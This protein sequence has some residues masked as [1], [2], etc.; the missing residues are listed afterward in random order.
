MNKRQGL[1]DRFPRALHDLLVGVITAVCVLMLAQIVAM[2]G[3]TGLL[4]L[5]LGIIAAWLLG[6]VVSKLLGLEL[7]QP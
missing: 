2:A 1:H 7:W 4:L 3:L 5:G 6:R